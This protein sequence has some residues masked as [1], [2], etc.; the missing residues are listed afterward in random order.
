MQVNQLK[1]NRYCLH[2]DQEPIAPTKTYKHPGVMNRGKTVPSH[3]MWNNKGSH[4]TYPIEHENNVAC[5]L[6]D[7]RRRSARA[8]KLRQQNTHSLRIPLH[9]PEC[10]EPPFLASNSYQQ[11]QTNG[12]SAC[13][14][15]TNTSATNQCVSNTVSMQD[16]ITN[17]KHNTLKQQEEIE[18]N[19]EPICVDDDGDQLDTPTGIRNPLFSDTP[20]TFI[21]PMLIKPEPSKMVYRSK[22]QKLTKEGVMSV[23]TITGPLPIESVYPEM[24]CI[25][26]HKVLTPSSVSPK[27]ILI[28]RTN[29]IN[30]T[31]QRLVNQRS[32]SAPAILH[33]NLSFEYPTPSK[34]SL[35]EV[36]N[37]SFDDVKELGEIRDIDSDLYKK[38]QNGVSENTISSMSNTIQN[39]K[40][41][42]VSEC[43]IHDTFQEDVKKD[44]IIKVD[45]ISISQLVQRNNDSPQQHC[46]RTCMI[47]PLTKQ[48]IEDS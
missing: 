22:D 47:S 44:E 25:N 17:E 15:G 6:E 13:Q 5:R 41:E 26:L 19:D 10:S 46:D 39:I 35:D 30:S 14:S 8:K 16:S 31:E 11:S 29:M 3:S 28:T 9:P 42:L 24:L 33:P 37:V 27:N 18:T 23:G 34:V 2:L 12:L 20:A 45:D 21:E 1:T 7:Y 43:P 40:D 32:H 48:D 4:R 36:H 38:C